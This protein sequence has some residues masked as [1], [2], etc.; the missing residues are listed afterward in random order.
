MGEIRNTNKILVGK[1]ERK[2]RLGR[3]TRRWAAN[4]NTDF[5]ETEMEGVDWI[6][7]TDDRD[8]WRAVVNT[9]MN[10]HAP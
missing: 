10:L 3:R 9:V 6:H 8:R 5:S 2:R 4:I 7:L 1:S